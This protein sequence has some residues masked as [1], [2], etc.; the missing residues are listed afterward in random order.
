MTVDGTVKSIAQKLND[1]QGVVGGLALIVA[2]FSLF[3][4]KIDIFSW[5]AIFMALPAES[6]MWYL[7]IFNFFVTL[8]IGLLLL[9][10][11]NSSKSEGGKKIIQLFASEL[12]RIEKILEGIPNLET[13]GEKLKYAL[14]EFEKGN[15][16]LFQKTPV[17]S[18]CSK[19][20][21]E[22]SAELRSL[23]NN[24]YETLYI[25]ERN[26]DKFHFERD[27]APDIFSIRAFFE[28]VKKA[29]GQ[30]PELGKVIKNEL[31]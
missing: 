18:A 28:N 27:S 1:N 13:D 8:L 4:F 22:F 30:I 29:R 17:Y 10:K 12:D 20:M 19:D 23:L 7:W 26:H 3:N 16:E 15:V 31:I 25:I 9:N 24:F 2:M 11:I 5:P 14:S 21:L 6:K